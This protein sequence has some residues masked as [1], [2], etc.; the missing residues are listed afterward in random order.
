MIDIDNSDG[1]E[2]SAFHRGHYAIG[3]LMY[4]PVKNAMMGVEYQWGR[5]ENFK[6]GFTSDISKVQVSFKYNFGQS[7]YKR[8]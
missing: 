6:D 3:N 1:Q 7:F 8:D 5:R 4:Y 2:S